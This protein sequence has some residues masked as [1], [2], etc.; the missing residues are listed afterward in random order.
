[1]GLGFL[2]FCLSLLM[3]LVGWLSLLAAKVKKFSYYGFY[4]AVFDLSSK[5]TLLLL[6]NLPEI[7]AKL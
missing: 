6:P 4:S 5:L 1:M 7:Y 2:D 3:V